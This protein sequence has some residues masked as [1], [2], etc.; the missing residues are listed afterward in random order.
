MTVDG[1]YEIPPLDD[2]PDITRIT[3]PQQGETMADTRNWAGFGLLFIGVV[4][5]GAAAVVAMWG[6]GAAALVVTIFAVLI[7]L[8]GAALVVLEQVRKRART[9]PA[10]ADAPAWQVIERPGE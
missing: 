10:S 9:I 7:L 5:A 8:A 1:P 2:A 3:E 4:V 6:F